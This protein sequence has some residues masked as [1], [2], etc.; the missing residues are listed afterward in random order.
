MMKVHFLVIHFKIFKKICRSIDSL[1]CPLSICNRYTLVTRAAATPPI[2]IALALIQN[3]LLK[4]PVDF[5][6]CTDCVSHQHMCI[7]KIIETVCTSKCQSRRNV[8]AIV[9]VTH[10]RCAVRSFN[11]SRQ[12]FTH[13]LDKCVCI[14]VAAIDERQGNT[15]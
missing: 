14:V 12:M 2:R 13:Q 5:L 8:K 11:I 6:D 1:D 10:V 7:F 15:V 4:F 9:A 3:F